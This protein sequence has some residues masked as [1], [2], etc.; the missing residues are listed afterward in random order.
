[1]SGRTILVT[2]AMG[3]IGRALTIHLER[4][5][6]EIKLRLL[7]LNVAADSGHEVVR[8][9]ILDPAC[10]RSACEGVDQVV[11]LAASMGVQQTDKNKLQCLSVNI[12]GTVNVLE[13]A[14][15]TGVKKVVF[16]SS[17]EV[18]GDARE[19]PISELTPLSPKSVYA[20]SKIAA[21]EYVRAY[22]QLSGIE[23]TILR[24]FN[25]YG[26]WQDERFAIS[27]F[28]GSILR[29]EPVRIY[30]DGNQVRAFCHALDAAEGIRLALNQTDSD[31][32]TFVLGNPYEPLSILELYRI[33]A[34]ACGSSQ[35]PQIVGYSTNDRTEEREIQQRVPDINKAISVLGYR[36]VVDFEQGIRSVVDAYRA[37]AA[38]VGA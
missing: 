36:P 19:L 10:L 38:G 26:P 11:H 1:V 23:H 5:S 3:L 2:G 4:V 9:S 7:D 13:A 24:F 25:I 34:S 30:G 8:G 29:E 6:P 15:S 33:I 14:V 22:T 21:E 17:S 32:Q 28:V 12:Q 18:Y 16:A 20:V 37:K 35:K 27:R 31:A